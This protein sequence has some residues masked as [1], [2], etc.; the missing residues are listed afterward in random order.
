[1][2]I[3]RPFAEKS[4]AEINEV[5]RVNVVSPGHTNTGLLRGVP[6]EVK[7]SMRAGTYLRRFAEP[8]EIANAILFLAS[9]ESDFIT[10]Q[11]LVVDGGFELK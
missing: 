1:M 10:G 6:E 5:L 7:Q 11:H 9:R 4:A 3:D 2:A 8:Q